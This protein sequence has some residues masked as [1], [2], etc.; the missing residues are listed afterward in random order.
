MNLNLDV[1]AN[2]MRIY[3]LKGKR[4][5][6][7]QDEIQ[8]MLLIAEDVHLLLRTFV[9]TLI[10]TGC[11][12]SE[13]LNM[14]RKDIHYH[15]QKITLK[16]QNRSGPVFR[17]VPVPHNY[18]DTLVAVHSILGGNDNNYEVKK[19]LWKWTRQH[20]YELIQELMIRSGVPAG[21]HRNP[22]GIRHAYGVN[23]VLCSVPLPFLKKWMGH[24]HIS[25]TA[26]YVTCL[27]L[28]EKELVKR[29]WA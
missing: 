22:K 18:I 8:E 1:R 3:D 29:M 13:A 12:I 10:Y 6:L 11:R 5:F 14:T 4:L 2:K 21:G 9:E 15:Q 24:S 25:T 16:S 26:I 20:A 19:P 17:D 7:Y 23:A 28:D 27:Q